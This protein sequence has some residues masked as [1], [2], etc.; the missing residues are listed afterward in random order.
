MTQNES[1][2]ILLY[3]KDKSFLLQLR[4]F[5][6]TIRFPGH[7]G[8]FSGALE[9]R[10]S[11]SEGAY[12]ELWEEIRYK[13]KVICPFRKYTTEDHILNIFYAKLEQSPTHLSLNE[14]VEMALFPIDEILTGRLISKKKG[15]YY[16]VA[17]ILLD[18]LKDFL[19]EFHF[20]FPK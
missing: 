7:W 8:A 1:T 13:P 6:P 4:D 5:I 9:A 12:R 10:E 18:I 15:E 14:G 17:P 11:A 19:Q 2:V 16:P 20:L 3:K